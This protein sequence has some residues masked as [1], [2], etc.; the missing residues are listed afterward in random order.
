MWAP[1][2]LV[3]AIVAAVIAVLVGAPVWIL[4]VVAAVPAVLALRTRHGTLVALGATWLGGLALLLATM[5]A[6]AVLRV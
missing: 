5:M 1:G 4:L 3:L 2:G 6:T